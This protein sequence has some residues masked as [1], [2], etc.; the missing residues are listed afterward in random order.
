MAINHLFIDNTS[1]RPYDG[2]RR[3]PTSLVKGQTDLGVVACL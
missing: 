3:V 2:G 1:P